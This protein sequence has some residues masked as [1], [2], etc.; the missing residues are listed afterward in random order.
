MDQ[1]RVSGLQTLLEPLI[2]TPYPLNNVFE[3][4]LQTACPTTAYRVLQLATYRLDFVTVER[5]STL[6]FQIQRAWI[7]AHMRLALLDAGVPGEAHGG[8]Q[9][10][11]HWAAACRP[12]VDASSPH[13][14]LEGIAFMHLLTPP[15]LV[16]PVLHTAP[17]AWPGHEGFSCFTHRPHSTT[18]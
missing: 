11:R 16:G 8:G 14:W 17:A 12:A 2:V 4:T 6:Y 7:G 13:H 5:Y 9:I 15:T 3:P 18:F 1:G 10:V